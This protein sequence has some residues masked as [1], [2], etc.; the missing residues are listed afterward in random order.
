MSLRGVALSPQHLE[1][2]ELAAWGFDTPVDRGSLIPEQL[3]SA[4][5][6]AQRRL[7]E[8][9]PYRAESPISVELSDHLANLL[10]TRKKAVAN[11]GEFDGLAWELAMVDLR[12]LIAFQ[13]RVGF[14]GEDRL[15]IEHR[16]AWRQLLDLALP[17]HA[18]S[19]SPYIEVASYRGRWFLRDGYHR[20]FRLFKQGISLVP[21][22]VVYA[23]TPVQ[24]GAV[25]SQFFAE[26]ILFSRC[27]PML[28]DFLDDEMVL[29]YLRPHRERAVQPFHEPVEAGSQNQEG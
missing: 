25:G 21:A 3:Q 8:C 4:A 29:S 14:A 18:P 22:V 16:A 11:S 19:R 9:E 24:M 28:K 2:R 27:P 26:G 23:E 13:R 7:A 12:Q 17:F 10:A 20:S 6:H 5:S 1:I 15:Q